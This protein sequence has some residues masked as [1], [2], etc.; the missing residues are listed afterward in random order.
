M[1]DSNSNPKIETEQSLKEWAEYDLKK[2]GLAPETFPIQLSPGGDFEGYKILYPSDLG[3]SRLKLRYPKDGGPKYLSAKGSGN[4]PYLPLPVQKEL[5]NENSTESIFIT[6]GEKK[7]ARATLDSFPCVGL[8]GVYGWKDRRFGESEFL[9]ELETLH[10]KGRKVYVVFDSDRAD[11]HKVLKAERA[12]AIELTRR[13]AGVFIVSLPGEVDGEKN[14]L[15]DY[16]KRHGRENFRKLI[17]RARPAHKVHDIQEYDLAGTDPTQS[18]LQCL[19]LARCNPEPVTW[20]IDGLVPEKFPSYLYAREGLGKSFVAALLATEVCRGG[21]S[22]MG[23]NYRGKPVNVLYVDYELSSGVHVE[24]GEKIAR[25]LNLPGIPE[26][27]FYCNPEVPIME[28]LPEI[29]KLIDQHDIGLV[30]VDAWQSAGLDSYDPAVAADYFSTMR[31]LGATSLTV[32]HEKKSQGGIDSG[33]DSFYGSVHKRTQVRSAFRLTRI[34]DGKNPMTLR[35]SQTKNSF[36]ALAE[37]MAFDVHFEGDRVL[38]AQSS[39]PNPEDRDCELIAETITELGADRGRVNAKAVAES[40][41]GV[42]SRDRVYFLLK[43]KDGGLWES[44][45]GDRKERLYKSKILKPGPIYTQDFRI[46]E[47]SNN[48]EDLP[49]PPDELF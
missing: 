36:G 2:S 14:G 21:G 41:E 17:E 16:L 10:W 5:E 45:P 12:L 23:H 27:L 6:E 46:L 43:H 19:R 47:N 7:A 20:L 34:G 25:G 40:L 18:G 35:L 13:G 44:R 28:A 39:A 37:D 49:P 3:F 32:D 22:F 29:K 1:S 48:D 42:I 4:R 33:G 30:I 38:F 26:N 31:S 8:P 9:P 11:N 15:D 24:R